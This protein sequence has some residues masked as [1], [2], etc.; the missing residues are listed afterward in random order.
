MASWFNKWL[1]VSALPACLYINGMKAKEIPHPLHLSVVEANHNAEE[2]TLEITCKIFRDDFEKILKQN[3]KTR[4]DL[5]NPPNRSAMEKLVKDYIYQ[6][7]RIKL[8]GKNEKLECLGFEFER[9]EDAVYCYFEIEDL[10]SI[11]QLSVSNTI[12]HDLFDDQQN[13]IHVTV[14]GNR[15]SSKLN[16]PASE[17]SFSF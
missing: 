2:K 6:H 15:K 14:D 3:F 8:E 13:I 7:L 1:I 9:G 4:V 5:I 10:K 11:K 17:A 16:Y 12:L